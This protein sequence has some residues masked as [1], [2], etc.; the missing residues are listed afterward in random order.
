MRS[1]VVR[2]LTRG[3]LPALAAFVLLTAP[4][5]ADSDTRLIQ[6]AKNR[7]LKTF[8]ELV[9]KVDVRVALPDGTTALHWAAHWNDAEAVE[10]LIR[11]GADVNAANDL[12]VTPLGLACTDGGPVVVASLLRAGADANAALPAGESP[13]MAA[14]RT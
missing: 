10:A 11:A 3:P 2:T 7:D 6:A 9:S 1:D 14:A 13:V 12:G 4:L 8:R 5:A